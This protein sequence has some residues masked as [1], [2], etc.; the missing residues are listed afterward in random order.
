[1]SEISWSDSN[2][3]LV[4]VVAGVG[5]A[6]T[7]RGGRCRVEAKRLRNRDCLRL[8]LRIVGNESKHRLDGYDKC[9]DRT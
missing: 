8:P 4:G 3:V 7:V 1:M 2:D 5:L 6:G 9:H